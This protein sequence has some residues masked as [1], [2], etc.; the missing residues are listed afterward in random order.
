MKDIPTSL[1]DYNGRPLLV[2]DSHGYCRPFKLSVAKC[3]VILAKIKSIEE[4]V[5]NNGGTVQKQ[6]TSSDES[7]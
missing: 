5:R 4:F 1:D 6:L 3:E 2:F 7:A